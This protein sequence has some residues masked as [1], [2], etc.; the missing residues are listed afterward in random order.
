MS[1]KERDEIDQETTTSLKQCCAKIDELKKQIGNFNALVYNR[2]NGILGEATFNGF[3]R[4]SQN[5]LHLNA[6]VADLYRHLEHTSEIHRKQKEIRLKKQRDKRN[7]YFT[8]PVVSKSLATTDF[9]RM[10]K[11]ASTTK[12]FKSQMSLDM[13]NSK[14]STTVSY[15]T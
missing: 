13:H 14:G 10:G 12:R 8:R 11:F 9:Q 1:D 4:G 5:E 7:G 6:V 15:R 3:T 2:S